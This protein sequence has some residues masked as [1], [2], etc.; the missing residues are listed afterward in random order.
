MCPFGQGEERK[1]RTGEKSEDRARGQS[2]VNINNGRHCT[3]QRAAEQRHH[4]G[5]WNK[6]RRQHQDQLKNNHRKHVMLSGVQREG[7]L[8][9]LDRFKRKEMEIAP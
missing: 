6:K 8:A 5:G 1:R 3:E 9:L 7:G 2:G 4:E